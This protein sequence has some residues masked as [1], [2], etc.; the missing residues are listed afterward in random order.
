MNRI[1]PS[2]L[3]LAA[4]LTVM[5]ARSPA[6]AHAIA[7][8]R[9]FPVTLTLDDPGVADEATLPAVTWQRGAGPSNA[10]QF[11]WEFDKTITPTTALIYNQGYDFLRQKGAKNQS[12]FENAVITGKWQPY[13]NAEHEFLISLGIQVEL[14]GGADTQSVGG[15]AFG[16]VSPTVYVGKGLGDLPVAALRPLALTGELSYAI[17]YRRLNQDADNN[18]N[19]PTLNAGMSIQYSLPYLQAQVKD[20]HLPAFVNRLVPL[21]ELTWSTPVAGPAYGFPTQFTIAPGVIYLGDT[22]QVGVEALIPGNKAT[23]QNVGVIA[24]LHFF[25]DDIFPDTLGR[26]LFR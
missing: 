20:Y 14:N 1:V 11:Q 7:G 10:W 12:G 25:F 5:L 13:V 26:P 4:A 8:D 17:P 6:H 15:D 22:F 3:A 21:V 9:V 24:Q 16:S 19:P 23:G 18:G 2:C